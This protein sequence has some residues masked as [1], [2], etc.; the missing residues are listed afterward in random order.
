MSGAI[1]SFVF[2][3]VLSIGLVPLCRIVAFKTGQV[4]HPRNDRWHRSSVP[5]LGGVAIAL[6]TLIVAVATGVAVELAAPL[7]GAMFIS[8]AGL[9][10]DVLSLKP[11]TKLLA[12]I[13][14]AA[15]L[16]YFG[17]RLNWIE[18]RLID[19]VLTMMWVVGLTNAFNLL[20]NMD[21]LCAGTA[22]VVAVMLGAG[23][24]EGAGPLR[25]GAEL[26][27]LGALAGA[28][29]GLPGL[30]LSARVDLHGR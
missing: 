26:S 18:S 4:A 15:W 25:A 28:V 1:W 21:G 3:L 13:V 6:A 20:D 27:W 7:A 9:A 30:Q 10:D 2:G 29:G 16:V 22:L 8:A 12:Q 11:A 23:L 17:Y 24:M 19:S 14:V 5:L